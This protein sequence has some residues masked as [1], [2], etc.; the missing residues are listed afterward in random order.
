MMILR[1]R[2]LSSFDIIGSREKAVAIVEIHE[3]LKGCEQEI[4][5]EIMNENKRIS[6][7]LEKLGEREGVCRLR[8]YR[9]LA[10]D[11]DTEV[12]HREHG[13]VL[14]LD[15]QKVYFSPREATERQR[16]AD[17]VR[18]GETILVMFS[19]V[20]PYAIAIAK[21]RDVAKIFAVE[22]NHAAVEYARL[23]IKA[24]KLDDKIIAVEG[25]V[26]TVCKEWYGECDRVVMP[27]PKGAENFLD[28]AIKCLRPSGGFV[29]FYSWGREPELFA[30]GESAICE[31]LR[32][33]GKNYEIIGRHVVLPY[34]PHAYKVCIDFD[35]K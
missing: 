32:Q 24:N 23:N 2:I 17:Q 20:G 5:H 1:P 22:I 27:L 14:K 28:V 4:A 31:H 10:G 19:G 33:L 21:K 8:K 12:V 15:P 34:S 16:I 6:S 11:M 30:N 18:D 35:V 7:V 29:H 25:D 3:K 9:L 13:F 26:V